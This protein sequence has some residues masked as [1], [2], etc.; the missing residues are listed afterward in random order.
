MRTVLFA[1]QVLVFLRF[2]SGAG[3]GGLWIAFIG[4]A[5]S[6]KAAWQLRKVSRKIVN[7]RHAKTMDDFLRNSYLEDGCLVVASGRCKVAVT[8]E[9][10]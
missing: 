5:I 7:S 4:C 9:F 3:F 8:V 2:F 1:E 6:I 10:R